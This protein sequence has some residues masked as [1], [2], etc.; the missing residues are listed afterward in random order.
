MPARIVATTF[1]VQGVRTDRDVRVALQELFD[2]FAEQGLGQ[3]TFELAAGSPAAALV[4]KHPETARP[5]RAVIAA[6][7]ARAG[8]FHLLRGSAR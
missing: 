2:I 5:D 4:V 1:Q 3:A 8:D 6:A 7:L